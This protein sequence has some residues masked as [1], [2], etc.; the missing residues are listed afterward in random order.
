MSKNDSIR[1]YWRTMPDDDLK[2]IYNKRKSG[3]MFYSTFTLVVLFVMALG[4][5]LAGWVSYLGS[6]S[7]QFRKVDNSTA[8]IVYYIAFFVAGCLISIAD[9]KSLWH[10]LLPV[11]IGSLIVFVLFWYFSF[12]AVLLELVLAVFYLRLRVLVEDID[13]LKS[14]PSYPFVGHRDYSQMNAMSQ[15]DQ[16]KQLENAMNGAR[17]EGYEHIFTDS[18]EKLEKPKPADNKDDHFQQHKMLY[19]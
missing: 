3:R 18:R 2:R 10:I 8:G 15:A 17:A 1:E 9:S 12:E 7:V 13:F 14:L 16:L 6:L 4:Y 5:G 11:P 19:K